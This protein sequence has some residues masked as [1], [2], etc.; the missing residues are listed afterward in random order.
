MENITLGTVEELSCSAFIEQCTGKK[1]LKCCFVLNCVL[2]MTASLSV[3]FYK[4]VECFTPFIWI[5]WF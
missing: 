5:P 1:E 2:Y 4:E 3:P